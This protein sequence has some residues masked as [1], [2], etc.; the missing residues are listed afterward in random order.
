MSQMFSCKSLI[1]L[2]L[3]CCLLSPNDL[4]FPTVRTLLLDNC[5]FDFHDENCSSGC[6]DFSQGCPKLIALSLVECMF[7]DAGSLKKLVKVTM[8]PNLVNLTIVDIECI[9]SNPHKFEI[10]APGLEDFTLLHNS[11]YARFPSIDFPAL[12][13]A[14]VDVWKPNYPQ[15]HR[16][17]G[18]HNAEFISLPYSII[19]ALSM[20][21]GVLEHQP[22]SPYRRLKSLTLKLTPYQ[23]PCQTPA[24]VDQKHWQIPWK[25]VTYFLSGSPADSTDLLIQS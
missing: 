19:Q 2:E 10:R 12:K 11:N 25:L 24:K 20:A 3:K 15:E 4:R 21:P 7:T 22:S 13:H 16:Q 14:V 23:K 1:T 18:L 6:L 17:E 9:L 8:G 5:S